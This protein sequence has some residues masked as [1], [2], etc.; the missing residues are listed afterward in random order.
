M[1]ADGLACTFKLR[2]G[3]KFH[4]GSELQAEDV[5]YTVD[6]MLALKKGTYGTL[7]AVSGAEVVD[8][9]TVV[10]KL[11]SPFSGLLDALVRLYIL[12]ADVVKE[13]EQDGDWGEA[14]LVDHDAGSGPYVLVS[15]E[16]EQQYVAEKF[17]DYFKG[18]EGK[19][20]DRVVF[21]IFKDQATRRLAVEEGDAD[22]TLIFDTDI[23]ETL[24]DVPGMKLYSDPTLNQL[25]VAFNQNNEYLKDVR[26]RRALSLVYDRKG[27][28]ETVRSGHAE[29]ARGPLPPDIPCFDDSIPPAEYNIDKAKELMAEAGYPDGGFELSMAYQGTLPEEVSTM[30]L[31]QAG[32]A[33]IG[34]T[35]KPMAM[36][37]SAKTDLFSAPETAPDM[38]TIWI[39]PGAPLADQFLFLLGHSSQSGAGGINFAY[40]SNPRFDELLE[41]GQK[42]L[43]PDKR[44][45]IYREA[46]QLWLED[47]PYADIVVGH[48]LAAERDYVRGYAWSPSHA[49]T[50]NAYDMYTEGKP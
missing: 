26:I 15:W 1:S 20:A 48:G 27:H 50:V 16:R 29:I 33:E 12:N 38:G 23:W 17:P 3:V 40:H 46:Q 11:K 41:A 39:Y 45:E 6:R 28:V 34:I 4:D 2:Q 30:E 5:Q 18:W 31:M 42:E 9:Y 19:H 7:S 14:W 43:D 21:R 49:F 10:L 36:E 35:I 22:W 24:K 13:N 37:W 32:A 44:C 47:V 8:D 25:Y